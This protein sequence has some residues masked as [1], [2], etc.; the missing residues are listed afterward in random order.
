M[1]ESRHGSVDEWIR[2]G[3][4]KGF[5]NKYRVCETEMT[6]RKQR[7]AHAGVRRVGAIAPSRVVPQE[8]LLL[9][10]QSVSLMRREV[11]TG[12]L[13]YPLSQKNH[14]WSIGEA[15][16]ERDHKYQLVTS[17]TLRNVN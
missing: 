12:V 5:F 9:S 10:L 2:E 8:F 13:F 1:V 7:S 15:K 16:R 4:Q 14:K 3:E 17:H 6:L 11:E